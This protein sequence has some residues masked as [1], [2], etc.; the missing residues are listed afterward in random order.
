MQ[1]A[2]G[3][4]S[5]TLPIGHPDQVV[6]GIRNIEPAGSEA[7]PLWLKKFS[8]GKSAI[9]VAGLTR[10]DQGLDPSSHRV[11]ALDLMVVTIGNIDDALGEGEAN[12]VL[13]A[14]LCADAV[15]VAE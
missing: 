7:N 4:Q 3:G 13:Q 2:G 11:E 6:V 8:L 5:S 14:H 15:N 1:L 12:G 9:A 10:P